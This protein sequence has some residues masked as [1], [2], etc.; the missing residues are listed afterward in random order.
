MKTWKG[1][2]THPQAHFEEDLGLY[3]LREY[4]DIKYYGIGEAIR[5][6]NILFLRENDFTMSA[7]QY[8]E[9]GWL[10]LGVG[11]GKFDE[12][13]T[14]NN[15]GRKKGKCAATLIAEDLG[16]ENLP[17]LKQILQFA[18]A[19]DLNAFAKPL[20]PDVK[21]LRAVDPATTVNLLN[22]KNPDNPWIAIDWALLEIEA[23]VWEQNE[24]YN[25][26]PKEALR[27]HEEI[28]GKFKMAVVESDCLLM[29]KY[30]RSKT[31]VTVQK[32]LK[33]GQVRIFTNNQPKIDM[34]A[35]AKLIRLL[36][37]KIKKETNEIQ[38]EE[39]IRE[40]TIRSVPEWCYFKEGGSLMNGS[41]TAPNTPATKISLEVITMAVRFILLRSRD[42]RELNGFVKKFRV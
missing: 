9:E 17:E 32:S 41:Q 3:E 33:N 4:G 25:V 15:S 20:P 29:E 34:Q 36:E 27:A 7:E 42:D 37:Y 31:D 23:K 5:N 10:L 13:A 28:D 24:F 30:Y 22:R 6:R 11:G 14:G 19:A 39:L 35:M 2:I 40:G 16:I 26:A 1:V 21:L 18:L 12:H 38:E 8:E